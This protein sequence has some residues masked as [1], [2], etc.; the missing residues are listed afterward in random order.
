MPPSV[1]DRLKA[2]GVKI[3]AQDLQ[4]PRP[5]RYDSLE[6]ALGGQVVQTPNGETF[7]VEGHYPTG[8][9]HGQSALELV[10]SMDVI[11]DWAG[12]PRLREIPAEGFAFLDTETSGLAGG[13]GTYTFLVGVGRFIG[14][15]FVLQQIFMRDPLDETGQ[16]HA[17]EQ[18]LAPVQAVVTYNGKAFDVPL[19]NTRFALL[20]LRSPLQDLVHVDLLHLARRLWRDRLPSRTLSNLEVQILG[21]LRSEQEIPGWMIPQIYFDYLRDHNPAPLKNVFYH[22]AMDVLSLAALLNYT[23]GL[24]SDPLSLGSR[25]G[26]DLIALAK[27]FEDLGDLER[28]ALLYIHGLEHEDVLNE[29]MPVAALLQALQ[30]LALIR[31]RQNDLPAAIML[32]EQ[33]ALHRHLESHVELAKA[34]E[35]QIKDLEQAIYWT[36]AAMR[37]IEGDSDRSLIGVYQARQWTIE[38]E[39]RLKRLQNK[40]N[41]SL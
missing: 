39:R 10:A 26:I 21:A 3:G 2:L 23:A 34:Y 12:V 15:E 1:S 24:L 37:L 7:V 40:R 16:M 31:K 19:L 13:T 18:F 25:Y 33:A 11:A 35:H 20:G 32:W 41:R 8:R 5:P 22:N 6:E 17:L 28:A 36:E 29:R 4:P 9:A 27:L 30:R 38:L 14:D